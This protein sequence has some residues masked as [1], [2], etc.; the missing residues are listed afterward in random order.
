MGAIYVT[1]LISV[2]CLSCSARAH[3]GPPPSS[4]SSP[5]LI[6]SSLDF[7]ENSINI[8]YFL[9]VPSVVIME[10]CKLFAKIT[11]RI[12]DEFALVFVRY[13]LEKNAFRREEPF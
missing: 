10:L 8:V 12:F 1:S 6:N 11:K 5:I 9:C 4:I 3:A 13:K 2:G 7:I